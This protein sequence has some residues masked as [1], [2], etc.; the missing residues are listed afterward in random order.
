MIELAKD[1]TQQQ[2]AYVQVVWEPTFI[3]MFRKSGELYY[4]NGSPYANHRRDNYAECKEEWFI[5][6]CMVTYGCKYVPKLLEQVKYHDN[7]YEEPDDELKEDG[8]WI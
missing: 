4:F 7:W 8:M 1:I 2:I 5:K 3:T 6:H